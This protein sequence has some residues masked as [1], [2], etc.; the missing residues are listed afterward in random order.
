MHYPPKSKISGQTD[1]MPR[2]ESKY[3]IKMIYFPTF[4]LYIQSQGILDTPESGTH[5]RYSVVILS[6]GFN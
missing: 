1:K 3:K 2:N 6:A 4:P 5:K